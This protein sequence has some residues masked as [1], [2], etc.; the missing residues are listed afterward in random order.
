MNEAGHAL[1]EEVAALKAALASAEAR[2][3]QAAAD[4]HNGV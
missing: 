4:A 1:A 2:G 3:L